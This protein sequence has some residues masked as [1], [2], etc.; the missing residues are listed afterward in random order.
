MD[1]QIVE[2]WK[3]NGTVK[4]MCCSKVYVFQDEAM[5]SMMMKKNEMTQTELMVMDAVSIAILKMAGND[6]MAHQQQEIIDTSSLL[7]VLWKY[8]K[9]MK[10][11]YHLQRKCKCLRQAP[12]IQ[13]TLTSQ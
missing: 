7:S 13:I 5:E 10:S 9:S 12:T 8:Q 4:M 1:A 3:T 2:L 6:L 11:S